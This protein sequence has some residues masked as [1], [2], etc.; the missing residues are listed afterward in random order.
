MAHACLLPAIN[1]LLDWNVPIH[2]L[3]APLQYAKSLRSKD[4]MAD[5]SGET[6]YS[7]MFGPD[8]CGYSTKKVSVTEPPYTLHAVHC[9]ARV[10]SNNCCCCQVHAILTDKK[11][12]NQENK[13]TVVPKTD[14]LTHVYTYVLHPNNT[15]QVRDSRCYRQ[16][17]VSN[18]G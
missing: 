7:L 10:P 13:A 5:F 14:R 8:V 6:P 15:Y 12:N 4:K 3:G 2:T 9:Q 16:A 1:P 11:G 17:M 18:A